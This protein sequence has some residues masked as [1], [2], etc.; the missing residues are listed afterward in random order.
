LHH[1]QFATMFDHWLI[2]RCLVDV[3]LE[4]TPSATEPGYRRR[5]LRLIVQCCLV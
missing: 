2:Q 1:Q 3:I 4:P 5:I